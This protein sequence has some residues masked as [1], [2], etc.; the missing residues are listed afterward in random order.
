ME[1]KPLSISIQDRHSTRFRMKLINLVLVAS[2]MLPVVSR[3]HYAKLDVCS[4]IIFTF[5]TIS[6]CVMVLLLHWNGWILRPEVTLSIDSFTDAVWS[7]PQCRVSGQSA[8]LLRCR[9]RRVPR[10]QGQIG[11]AVLRSI[12]RHYDA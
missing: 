10:H 5:F 1:L 9:Y 7:L 6:N 12:S 4:I 8:D 2:G 3:N 11:L